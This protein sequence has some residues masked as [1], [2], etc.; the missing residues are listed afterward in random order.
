MMNR[1]HLML[2]FFLPACF[3][4]CIGG[5]ISFAEEGSPD[6]PRKG[7]WQPPDEDQSA[8]RDIVDF[9]IFRSD[10]SKLAAQVERDRNP[11][12]LRERVE[13]TRTEEEPPPNPDAVWRLSG[14]SHDKNG[15]VAYI[16]NTGSGEL[17]RIEGAADFSLG[18]I[19]TIGYDSVIY[20]I[21]DKPRVVRV[22]ETLAGD[23]VT[24][25]GATTTSGASG[26]SDRPTSLEERIRALRE[27]RARELGETPA[28][29]D[30]P[31]TPEDQP[32]ETDG[33]PE[34]PD[35]TT[36]TTTLSIPADDADNE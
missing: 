11:P 32:D 27:R 7:A 15:A 14:I 9:N 16:E 26:T 19:T 8:Y 18:K 2:Y 30:Q 35:A 3:T 36:T 34:K 23:R 1:K 17:S 20:V 31:D 24:P 4:L 13:P 28:G 29:P 12:E 25:P 10:R 33:E 21:D 22:G 6:K 5:V